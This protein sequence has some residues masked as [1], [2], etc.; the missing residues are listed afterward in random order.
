M[1]YL[2]QYYKN[3]CEQLEQQIMILEK[4]I[5][6]KKSKMADRD[7]DGDGK[8]ESSTDEWKGSRDRAIKANMQEASDIE[9]VEELLEE[10]FDENDLDLIIEA[11]EKK[12][13][14]QK[15]IKKEGSLRKTLKA[16]KGEKI[17]EKK[18]Q[19]AAKKGGKTGKRARLALTLKKLNEE[20][21]SS[22]HGEIASLFLSNSHEGTDHTHKTY[23]L[24][25]PDLHKKLIGL[26]GDEVRRFERADTSEISS[27][28]SG[29]AQSNKQ[30]HQ[31]VS[32]LKASGFDNH[33]AIKMLDSLRDQYNDALKM[34][35]RSRYDNPP[36]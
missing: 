2:D 23:P 1:N 34:S 7:Y 32:M 12:K 31:A 22:N 9:V 17:P 35:E 19:A 10:L 8:I 36:R 27:K 18:L 3:I 6:H 11:A 29:L 13:W 15:A 14:I 26:V 28:L 5:K 25:P 4:K 20:S 21:K 24:L 16:K 33:P 30:L